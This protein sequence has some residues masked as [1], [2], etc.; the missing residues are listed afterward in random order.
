M[1]K[2]VRAIE[3][4]ANTPVGEIDREEAI[5]ILRRSGIIT[6]TNTIAPKYADCVVITD[7]SKGIKKSARACRSKHNDKDIIEDRTA[8]KKE[9]DLIRREAIIS[10]FEEGKECEGSPDPWYEG[11]NTGLDAAQTISENVPVIDAI[12]IEWMKKQRDKEERGTHF[13][14]MYQAII[15]KWQEEQEKTDEID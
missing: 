8:M 3:E 2:A 7:H 9:N 11:F 15:N 13:W 12:P 1:I 6:E 10:E 5:K 14:W 4:Y